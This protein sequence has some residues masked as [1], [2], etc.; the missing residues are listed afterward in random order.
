MVFRQKISL[1]VR[2]NQY[3]INRKIN[4]IIKLRKPKANLILI[5][6]KK[7]LEKSLTPPFMLNIQ[8][9]KARRLF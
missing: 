9:S 7:K 6:I 3:K 2:R 1:R 5:K 4:K 8:K